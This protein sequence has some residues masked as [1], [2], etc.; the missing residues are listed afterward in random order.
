MKD[1]KEENYTIG[2][3]KEFWEEMWHEGR[4]K[5]DVGY[6]APPI[7]EY[8]NQLTDKSIRIL[9]PGAGN[10]YEAEYLH[11]NGFENVYVLDIASRPL[12]NFKK[13]V[14]DFP[15]E[16]LLN[17]NFFEHAEKYDLIIEQ[18]FFIALEPKLRSNYAR[19]INELLNPGG[20]LAGLLITDTEPSESGPPFIDTKEEYIKH[21]ERIFNI[22]VY[23]T[24]Y[25]SIKPRAGREMFINFVK[26]ETKDSH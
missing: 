24:A 5:W 18:T 2:S 8:A 11:Q 7:I 25:N 19:K 3:S 4:T 16:H 6:A 14:T 26:K 23:E 20:K 12:E 15:E 1:N 10:A 17:Q 13:R 9:I 21:F 22:K